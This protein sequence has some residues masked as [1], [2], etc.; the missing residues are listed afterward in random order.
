MSKNTKLDKIQIFLG[1]P[2]LNYLFLGTLL[3]SE[4]NGVASL[5]HILPQLIFPRH[6]MWQLLPMTMMSPAR[7]WL[8]TVASYTNSEAH[9]LKF[10]MGLL[11]WVEQICLQQH[12]KTK[13]TNK[14]LS[15]KAFLGFWMVLRII[16]IIDK[17]FI[18]KTYTNMSLSW[19]AFLGLW[20]KFFSRVYHVSKSRGNS[21]E[22]FS[23]KLC[24]LK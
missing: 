22:T 17:T 9:D 12:V 14:N 24:S 10:G 7:L 19:K 5:G 8:S 23:E 15:W 13:Y 18:G 6:W 3:I 21:L 4:G 11:N 16:L 20:L 1:H 2:V